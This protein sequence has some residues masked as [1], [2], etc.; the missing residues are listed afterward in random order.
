MAS[1]SQT[2]IRDSEA[3]LASLS[4][5]LRDLLVE[6]LLYKGVFMGGYFETLGK[7][8]ESED[9][10]NAFTAIIEETR[11]EATRTIEVL[12]EWDRYGTGRDVDPPTRATRARLFQDLLAL[13]EGNNDVVLSA[14]MAAPTEE[15]RQALI[16]LADKDREHA[17]ILRRLLGV[18]GLKERMGKHAAASTSEALG[19]HDSRYAEGPLRRTVEATLHRLNE[20]GHTPTR[21][22]VSANALRALRDEGVVDSDAGKAFGLSVDVD[23]GWEGE[24]FSVITN[25]RVSLS[26]IITEARTTGAPDA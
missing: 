5:P 18:R 25:E 3:A 19:A 7:E 20:H 21:L 16:A 11:Q 22:V 17:D 8:Y 26:A 4:P 15:L 6:L 1:P 14:A 9:A 10:R 12:Q 13:K 23:L 24:C 2:L